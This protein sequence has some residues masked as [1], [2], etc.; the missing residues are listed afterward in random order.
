MFLEQIYAV[1]SRLLSKVLSNH[2]HI[3][4]SWDWALYVGFT[5]RTQEL[6]ALSE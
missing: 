1:Y 3:Y 4:H 6:D 2:M 5:V